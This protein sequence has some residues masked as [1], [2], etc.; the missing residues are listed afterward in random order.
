LGASNARFR[1][2]Y[3]SGTTL[4]TGATRLESDLATGTL[5]I[6]GADDGTRAVNAKEFV[7]NDSS[8]NATENV[9]IRKTETGIE[10]VRKAISDGTETVINIGTGGGA[11]TLSELTDVSSN[12][13][14]SGQSLVWDGAEWTPT[15]LSGSGGISNPVTNYGTITVSSD[16]T[17]YIMNWNQLAQGPNSDA[18]H[19]WLAF[20]SGNYVITAE[21]GD[22]TTWTTVDTDYELFAQKKANTR[23]V[24]QPADYQAGNNVYRIT[25]D[26]NDCPYSNISMMLLHVG[27]TSVQPNVDVLFEGTNDDVTWNTVHETTGVALSSKT[28]ACPLSNLGGSSAYR[29]TITLNN[30]TRLPL[31]GIQLM[32]SRPGSQ[33]R[34]PEYEF[35]Y[36]WSGDRIITTRNDLRTIGGQIRMPNGDAAT[37]S[38]SFDGDQDTGIFWKNYN[39]IGFAAQGVE[40]ANL[41]G[42]GLTLGSYAKVDAHKV[43]ARASD[44]VSLTS[45]SHGFQIGS[46]TGTNIA[47]DNNEIMARNNGATSTLFIQNDGGEVHVGGTGNI[48]L[49]DGEIQVNYN[50]VYH[51]GNL[52]PV[53]ASSTGLTDMQGSLRVRDGMELNGDFLGDYSIYR[54]LIMNPNP[55]QDLTFS[56]YLVNDFAFARYRGATYTQ[57]NSAISDSSFD[58]MFNGKAGF[59][60]FNTNGATAV[61][62]AVNP[63]PVIEITLPSV[64]NYASYV[65]V[66]FGAEWNRARGIRLEAFSEGAWIDV[67]N[68]SNNSSDVVFGK[69]DGNDGNGTSKL[70]ITLWN[71]STGSGDVRITHI[72]GFDYNS[73]LATS[74]FLDRSGGNVYGDLNIDGETTVTGDLAVSGS[75]TIDGKEVKQ[76]AQTWTTGSTSGGGTFPKYFLLGESELLAQYADYN[77][78]FETMKWTDSDGELYEGKLKWGVRSTS[79]IAEGNNQEVYLKLD[80]E[81]DSSNLGYEF[82]YVITQT[83]PS[84][85]V[86]LWCKLDSSYARLS[87][88]LTSEIL[89]N[90]SNQ[91]APVYAEDVYQAGQLNEPTGYVSGITKQVAMIEPGGAIPSVSSGTFTPTIGVGTVTTAKAHWTRV[92]DQ[93]TVQFLLRG[94]SDTST[95]SNI[96]I[97]NMPFSGMNEELTATGHV[98]YKYIE[99]SEFAQ[100]GCVM[101]QWNQTDLYFR[102]YGGGGSNGSASVQH[103]N[104]NTTNAANAEIR[105]TISY[106]TNDA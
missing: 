7:L 73:P 46:D 56:P 101:G 11:S 62:D 71:S 29:I 10:F 42:G 83:A 23:Y 80:N 104:I 6:K 66:A 16:T 102:R 36:A 26:G 44:D 17:S 38:L 35:P 103:A 8:I 3:L 90:G 13:P 60:T 100:M 40:I 30:D 55:E 20:G 57:T 45:T 92:G 25:I 58:E 18:M 1:T 50:T 81:S 51:A 79:P 37:P 97:N 85:K 43:R 61:D 78:V 105:G 27:Y 59:A 72:F 28:L 52:T 89:G 95:W 86:Q 32:T 70:R 68:E 15:T 87:G 67:V 48:K 65:G 33:G 31:N 69:I 49:M 91:I 21:L 41:S 88:T 9:V 84:F 74:L 53:D 76:G 82:G 98:E 19:D 99:L 106:R 2:L 12:T 63:P 5:T 94:F 64:M 39:D 47:M 34:G 22:G 93:V 75:I 54:R 14:T 96:V 24:I 4:Y 77:A